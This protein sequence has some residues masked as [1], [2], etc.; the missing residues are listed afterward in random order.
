MQV[1]QAIVAGLAVTQRPRSL[2][3]FL[4]T[5]QEFRVADTSNANNRELCKLT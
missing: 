3:E 5:L 2:Q 1:M 4:E